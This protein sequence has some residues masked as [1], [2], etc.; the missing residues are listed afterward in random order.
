MIGLVFETLGWRFEIVDLDGRRIDK[1][2][3][4]RI[5]V[6]RVSAAPWRATPSERTVG[7][8]RSKVGRR[9]AH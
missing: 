5:P 1:I 6:H 9:S 8:R 7:E 4:K 2:L 3:A